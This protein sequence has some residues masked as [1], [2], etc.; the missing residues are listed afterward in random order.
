[1]PPLNGTIMRH[2]L[3]TCASAISKGCVKYKMRDHYQV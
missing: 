2:K 1:M 3:Q